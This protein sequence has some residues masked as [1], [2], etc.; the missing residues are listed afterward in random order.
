MR[1]G[2]LPGDS[3][4]TMTPAERE[5]RW[6]LSARFAIGAASEAEVRP[7]PRPGARQLGQEAAVA[8]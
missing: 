1:P 2:V 6:A 5:A 3:A 7:H 4:S 8:G